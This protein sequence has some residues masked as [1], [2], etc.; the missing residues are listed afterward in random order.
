MLYVNPLSESSTLRMHAA[1]P[2]AAKDARQKQALQELERFFAYTLLKE[3][4]RTTGN[5]GLFDDSSAQKMHMELLDDA[6]AKG[7]AESGQLGIASMIEAQLRQD[8][9]AFPQSALEWAGQAGGLKL[10]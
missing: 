3:M 2:E 6:L 10:P 1:G 4:R 5:N 7:I 9:G 8:D